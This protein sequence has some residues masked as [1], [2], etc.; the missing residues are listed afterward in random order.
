MSQWYAVI[1]VIIQVL[2]I[3]QKSGVGVFVWVIVEVGVDILLLF[4]FLLVFESRVVGSRMS[5]AWNLG[6]A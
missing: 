1:I 6:R 2:G 5:L 4:L 3:L